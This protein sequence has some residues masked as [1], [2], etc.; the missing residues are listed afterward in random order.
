MKKFIFI[1][2]VLAIILPSYSDVKIITD[3]YLNIQTARIDPDVLYVPNTVEELEEAGQ[4]IVQGTLLND[5]EQK[6]KAYKNEAKPYF[7]ITVSSF[8]IDKVYKGDLKEGAIIKLGE[9]Y[10]TYDYNNKKTIC[11]FGNYMP[12]EVGKE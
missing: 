11:H 1:I 3:P 10:F 9:K 8:K 4:Y 6:T 2:L 12:S 7:G 5:A